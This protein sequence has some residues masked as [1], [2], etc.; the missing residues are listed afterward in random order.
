ML[1]PAS[2]R[3]FEVLA[4]RAE[5]V[6]VVT[7]LAATGA[8]E[9]ELRTDASAE[10]PIQHL[11]P[12]LAEYQ[13]LHQRYGRY[14]T[15]GRWRRR[16]LIEAPTVVVERA[17]ARIQAWRREAD[18]VIALLQE[19]E[20]ELT[21][22]K[23]LA[24]IIG[25]I[26]EQP[27]DFGAV[28][29]SGPVLGTFCA[30]LPREA[31]LRLPDWTIPR[32][33]P[34]EDERCYMILGPKAQLDAVKHQVQSLKG[35]IIERPPWLQGD[36]LDSLAR[37]RARREFLSRRAVNLTAELDNLFEDY[38]LGHALG[39]IAGLAWFAEHVEGFEPAGTHLVWITGWTDDLAGEA[40]EQALTA[41]GARALLR[42]RPP[43]AGMRP[44]QVLLNPPWMRPFE[45]FASAFGVPGSDEADPTPVLALVVPL[46]FGYMFGDL[47]QG[48]VIAAAGWWLARRGE[49]MGR[50]LL[51]AGLSAM[52]FGLLFGSVFAREDLIPAL[53]LHPLHAPITVLAVPLVFAVGLLAL[54]QLLAGLGALWRGELG[55]WLLRDLGFLVL[56]L[57][58]VSWPW[59]PAG[60][61]AALVGALWYVIGSFLIHRRLLGGLAALGHLLESGMQI[62]VNTL[63]FARVGAF[64]LAHAS[65]SA[66]VVTM[67][68]SAPWW[69]GLII[70]VLGNALII[71]LEGLVVSIQTTRLVLFEFF[72]RFLRGSGRVFRPLPPPPE[73]VRAAV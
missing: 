68:D 53:W 41:S 59:F 46:L 40:L 55:H 19:C 21:R 12:G 15:R 20:E 32:S 45:L 27:L 54:G 2:T 7:A 23:W 36:A 44:P 1:R 43:P 31:D 5:G 38:D 48:A 64:A 62:L 67:A 30:I 66:A 65:L 52:V 49:S 56:Y 60:G 33:V 9:T 50:L 70:L 57:G 42:L 6:R 18:P 17:L 58:L 39:E 13:A 4:P 69:A 73:V 25:R 8:V 51:L 24:Q 71:V 29:R 11:A 47:G 61:Q 10:L 26:A 16:T 37:I 35:R 3:W 34:W 72:N 63:S 22:L 28:A 14:W